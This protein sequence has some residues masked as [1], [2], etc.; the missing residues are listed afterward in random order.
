MEGQDII[1]H[2]LIFKIKLILFLCCQSNPHWSVRIDFVF[3]GIDSWQSNEF[4]IVNVDS[5]S[6]TVIPNAAT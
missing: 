4:I 2:H 5:A 3:L 1:T 6:K